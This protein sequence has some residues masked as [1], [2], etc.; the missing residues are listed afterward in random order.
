MHVRTRIDVNEGTFVITCEAAATTAGNENPSIYKA[1]IADVPII[2][3]GT[4]AKEGELLLSQ[5]QYDES[6]FNKDTGSLI[7]KPYN[8]DADKYSLSGVDLVYA[9]GTNNIQQVIVYPGN[10]FILNLNP[11][12]SGKIQFTDKEY[13]I[14]G[15]VD[16]DYRVTIDGLY[17]DEWRPISEFT[18]SGD[19]FDVENN[20]EL[21]IRIRNVGNTN[22]VFTY[23]N[24]EG[25]IQ[26]DTFIAPILNES[27][28]GDLIGTEEQI[29]L[30]VNLFKK[31][32]FRGILPKYITRGENRSYKEDQDFVLFFKSVA[33]YFSLIIR[34]FKRWENWRNDFDLLREQLIG[35]GIYFDENSSTLR[36]LQKLCS[37]I[38]SVA[39]QR[40][41]EMI[42]RRKEAAN[43]YKNQEYVDGEFLRLTRNRICDELDYDYIPKWNVG[44]CMGQGSPMYAGTCQSYEL[45]KTRENSKDFKALTSVNN[46]TSGGGTVTI[47]TIDSK[48]TIQLHTAANGD[49]A[50]IG[51]ITQDVELLS[52][53]IVYTADAQMDYEITFAFR[54]T[55]NNFNKS[56]LDFGVEGFDINHIKLNDAFVEPNGTSVNEQFFSVPLSKF[57]ED[58]WYYVRGIIHAYSTVNKEQ[59]VTNIGFGT[60]LYFCNPFVKYIMPYIKLVGGE[61]GNANVYIWDYKIRPLV[62]GRNILPLKSGEVDYRSLGFLQFGRFYYTYFHNRNNTKSVEEVT[63]IIEKY[64][65]PFDAI[66]LFTITGNKN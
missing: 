58:E 64:L 40:G 29:K 24:I 61:S 43:V 66:N 6:E 3:D 17:W 65:Y 16:L 46:S 15:T 31:L 59:I 28:F 11:R 14:T 60:D 47:Q 44:W 41:T 52:G 49:E 10:S 30:E 36:D 25:T 35:Y 18:T 51:R 42:Y 37:E 13:N 39:Q 34:F 54:I 8:D 1:E 7:V 22:S 27:V 23:F 38:Y 32:Y 62:R 45:N 21:Q 48:Q 55:D 5:E 53:D 2:V 26:L 56:T 12:L 19:E 9:D 20:I 33:R 50:A 57:V 4:H 63:S